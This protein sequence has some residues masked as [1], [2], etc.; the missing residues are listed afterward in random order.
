MKIIVILTLT[1]TFHLSFGQV[2]THLSGEKDAYEGTS[3][4]IIHDLKL[5]P[6]FRVSAGIEG[7]F[8]AKYID[9]H[10]VTIEGEMINYDEALSFLIKGVVDATTIPVGINVEG[11]IS[12]V[13]NGNWSQT[14]R[15][16]SFVPSST[17]V[18]GERITVTIS[19]ALLN[20]NGQSIHDGFSIYYDVKSEIYIPDLNFEL[21][22]GNLGY[23]ELPL[24]NFIYK[25]DVAEIPSL[26]VSESNIQD[27]TGLETFRQLQYLDCS[28]NPSLTFL[29]VSV[30]GQ[31]NFI[32][33]AS[34][35][36]TLSC[37]KVNYE[38]SNGLKAVPR[39]APYNSWEI[40][41]ADY[42][43][44]SCDAFITTWETT[45]SNE[46]ITIPTIEAFYDYSV[47]WG[48]GTI[49]TGHDGDA[50]H[51]YSAAGTYIVAITG[52]FPRIYF[53]NSG[54]KEKIKSIEQWGDIQWTSMKESFHG[55]KNLVLT[56]LDAP[57]LSQV[58]SMFEMFSGASSIN[59]SLNHWDVRTINDMSGL[60][61]YAVNFNGEISDWDVSEVVFM[62]R[63]FSGA[64]SFN[65]NI[66]NWNTHKVYEMKFMFS[67]ASS[68]NG[69]ISNWNVGQV[70]LMSS[71][72]S[73][74]SS[75]NRNLS[76]WKVNRVSKMDRMFSYA[77]S[78]NQDISSWDISSIQ[79]MSDMLNGSGLSVENYELTLTGW[80]RLDPGELVI[81]Q[82]IELGAS[83]MLYCDAKVARDIL[84]DQ[85]W[86]IKGDIENCTESFFIT[87]WEITSSNE[88]ITIPIS[89]IYVPYC[90]FMVDWGDGSTSFNYGR[91]PSHAYSTAGTYEVKISGDVLG[92]NFGSSDDKN[93]IKTIKQWGSIEWIS[94]ESAFKGCGELTITATDAP[95]FTSLINH[96]LA[97][98]FLG[99][100]SLSGDFSNW[101]VSTI[102][103]MSRMFLSADS[104]N[105]NLSSWDISNIVSMQFM[106][107]GTNLSEE[108][109]DNTLIGW[110]TLDLA[111][112]ETV[113]PQNVHLGAEGLNYCDGL[114]AWNNLTDPNTLNW[115]ITGDS[116][117]CSGARVLEDQETVEVL[118]IDEQHTL[119]YPNPAQDHFMLDITQVK[120]GTLIIYDLTGSTLDTPIELKEGMNLIHTDHLPSGLV[121][122]KIMTDSGTESR[123]L[124][125]ER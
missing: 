122:L 27:L 97:N 30:I 46:P 49:T 82:N 45:A 98:M 15:V 52:D 72:F 68:F 75:F 19:N 2:E 1:L 64:S 108:N 86:T 100:N 112:G 59:S 107:S 20:Q 102:T 29:D 18:F 63:M 89:S 70:G 24:Q 67:G 83:H 57:D 37:V 93:K 96:S 23:D 65:G 95:D 74:A 114:T 92:L 53:N 121:L 48:D 43:L 125:I 7:A 39:S 103:S 73:N 101:D 21:A 111:V 123:K 110:N 79:N 56:A 120:G 115:T 69:D 50:T 31:S 81:P 36:V 62:S 6:G 16:L 71:M 117:S 47:D 38:Q 14:G 61:S 106:L 119:V 32:L 76:L 42:S 90:G 84:I 54:D 4:E 12:G 10:P 77:S 28:K 109:Y 40:S 99:A 3:Y 33:N 105:E 5:S 51:I 91:T 26:D 8:Q 87:T 41:D 88:R 22:L 124:M 58:Q 80:S 104:F 66:S 11:S 13:V 55:C 9:V 17:Y 35:N 85:S 34:N 78:F 113:V 25:E 94:M 116:Y 44:A 118:E 60:F